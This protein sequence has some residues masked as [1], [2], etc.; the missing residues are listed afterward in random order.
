MKI[1]IFGIT[2]DKQFSWTEKFEESSWSDEE[3]Y[4]ESKEVFEHIDD[5][6]SFKY[7][8]IIDVAERC[9]D[10]KEDFAV[11]LELVILPESCYD[12][13]G[14]AEFSGISE[15]DVTWWDLL[16]YGGHSVNFG[17]TICEESEIEETLTKIANVFE[18]MDGLRG[19]FLDKAWNRIGSTG[20]DTI[21]HAVLGDDLFA[22]AM[23]SFS[24]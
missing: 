18:S 5:D 4:F 23:K 16:M 14:V 3:R 12:L 2:T 10:R 19:F 8:Y 11:S 17:T 9:W 7:K 24:A 15:E 21:L 13:D 6:F 1:T 20:W 22:P